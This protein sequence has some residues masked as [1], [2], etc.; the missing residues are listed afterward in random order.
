MNTKDMI[1]RLE[2]KE[3]HRTVEQL[4]RECFWNV[5]APGCTEHYVLHRL[6]SHPDF[7]PELDFVMEQDGRIIGQMVFVRT[8]LALDDGRKLP[9]MTMGP[10]CID[11]A[12]QR[13]GYGKRLLDY[14]LAQAKALGCKAVCFEG[15]MDFYGKSGFVVAATKGIRYHG[16]PADASADFFLCKELV[17]GYLDGISG[18]YA[19][20]QAYFAA[21]D[22][23]QDFARYD[24]T[25]PAKEN[26][27]LPGQLGQ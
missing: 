4:V 5:Y 20:P 25:F 9:I 3:D 27:I 12:L 7:V 10:I 11:R 17:P 8:A 18:E 15:N 16:L 1:I 19:T 21:V 26:L 6:R 2:K 14:G 23:P 13:R 24:A 22:N